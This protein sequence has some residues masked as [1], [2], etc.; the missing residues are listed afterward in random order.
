MARTPFAPVTP[1]VLRWAR[2]DAG[3]SVGAV[4]KRADVKPDV[5]VAW[6][7]AQAQPTLAQLRHFADAVRRP[8]A[9]FFTADP[10]ESHAAMPPD[11]RSAS[12]VPSPDL[13]REIRKAQ[14]RRESFREL[15]AAVAWE[16]PSDLEGFD[17]IREWLGVGVTEIAETAD[18]GTALK[19]WI[20]A[21]EDRGALVFQMSGIGT[22]ECRGFSLADPTCPVIVLNGADAPQARSFTLLHEVAHL[23]GREGGMCLLQDEVAVERRCNQVAAEILMPAKVIRQA[24]QTLAGRALVDDLVRIFRVS[25]QAAA[26][27]LRDLDLLSQAVVDE[28]IERARDAARRAESREQSGGPLHYVLARRNLG[29]RYISA[30]LDA[31]HSDAITLTDAT[32]LLDERVGTLERLEQSLAGGRR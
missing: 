31:L 26:F 6:E 9:F 29:D 22:Q 15:E 1:W 16:P 2:D 19:V 32:Y 27:R 25:S 18:P 21:V 20:G 5:V 11:Y 8:V 10:P 14:E 24:A 13:R 17:A 12:G 4:A 3:L 30:V 28:V 23:L 7:D